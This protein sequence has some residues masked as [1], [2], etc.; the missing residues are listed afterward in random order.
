[1]QTVNYKNYAISKLDS[2]TIE[3]TKDGHLISPT[4]PI[5]R[6]L[7]Q[8]LN[9][10]NSDSHNTRQLGVL[11]I[12]AIKKELSIFGLNKEK[13]S[14]KPVDNKPCCKKDENNTSHVSFIDKI[15]QTINRLQT[16]YISNIEALVE[17]YLHNSEHGTFYL[18]KEEKIEKVLVENAVP[19]K[20]GVYII[21]S[22][23]DSKEK[24][25]YIGKAG[26]VTTNGNF[27]NQGIK[28]RLKA[29][30]T[31]NMP[32]GKYFQQEVIQKYG[33]DK[34]KFVWIVTFDD[35]RKELPACS[36]ARLMQLYYDVYHELPMLNKSF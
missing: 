12:R 25:I 8:E 23:K 15:K 4:K 17:D 30:T 24:L 19:N 5:L 31:N 13:G 10:K 32:R 34:L 35:M 16:S 22:V 14:T 18:N 27:K 2:G 36:E 9:I 20:H 28:D 7:A 11:V 26:T 6:A 1:M 3:V 21:Y 33:F 29:V